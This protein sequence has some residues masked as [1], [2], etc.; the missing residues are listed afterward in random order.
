M[1]K[2]YIS[3]AILI[4]LILAGYFFFVQDKE[5]SAE[6]TKKKDT[7]ASSNTNM[8]A[9]MQ[10]NFGEIK[11]ELFSADAPKTVENFVKLSESG[12]YDNTKFHRVIKEFMIQGGDPLTKDDSL[13]DKWGTG[14]PGYSF[15]DEIHLNNHNVVGTISMANAGPNT[16]GSQFFINTNDNGFLDAK[17]TVFGK[18]IQGMDVVRNIENVSTEGPDRPVDDAI[19]QSIK[20]DN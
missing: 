3:L 14:G 12:F 19:I 4:V 18:I 9:I 15:L 5:D 7:A 8:I 10:T 1:N 20:I 2:I 13:K 6:E 17:H 16:N 11:I